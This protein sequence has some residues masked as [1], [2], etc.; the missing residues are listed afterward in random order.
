MEA[1]E[2]FEKIG[3]RGKIDLVLMDLTMPKMSGPECF[4]RLRAMDPDL[5]VLI[6]S[7]YSLDVDAENLLKGKATGFLPKPYDLNQLLDS[8]DRALNS[9]S[10]QADGLV[11]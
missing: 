2:E 11:G 4:Q 3:G 5:R 6:S 7:G 8:V 1:I 10:T 9:T